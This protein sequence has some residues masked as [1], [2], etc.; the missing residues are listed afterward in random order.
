MTSKFQIRAQISSERPPAVPSPLNGERVRVRG[1]QVVDLPIFLIASATASVYP[2]GYSLDA[3]PAP[4]SHPKWRPAQSARPSIENSKNAASECSAISSN[5]RA[6]YPL[7]AAQEIHVVRRPVPD[8]IAL[9]RKRN[10]AS[11]RRPDAAAGICKRRSAGRAESPTVSSPPKWNFSAERGKWNWDS[12]SVGLMDELFQ[13]KVLFAFPP[14]T[15]A[16]SPLRGEGMPLRDSLNLVALMP[17][18][19]KARQML[20]GNNFAS[21]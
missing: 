15:L 4:A 9:R 7:P 18:M 1:G 17:T 10:R 8:C 5:H 13:F 2:A 21:C 16:L 14:L 11:V 20:P 6:V 12:S 19:G 3:A